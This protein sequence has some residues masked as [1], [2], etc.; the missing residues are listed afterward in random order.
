MTPA[1]SALQAPPGIQVGRVDPRRFRPR[2][3]LGYHQALVATVS[4]LQGRAFTGRIECV[5]AS[6]DTAEAHRLQLGG[7]GVA[8]DDLQPTVYY[9]ATLRLLRDLLLQGWTVSTDDDGIF[10]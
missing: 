8:A 4:D 10:I 9:L 6:I 3:S 7:F 2:L 1:S 5:R